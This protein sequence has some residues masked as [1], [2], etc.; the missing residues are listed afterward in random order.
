MKVLRMC[1]ASVLFASLAWGEAIVRS[2]DE[3]RKACKEHR[4]GV[5]FEIDA[6]VV[7]PAA[8]PQTD[9]T[10]L[11]EGKLTSVVDM[12]TN[13]ADG[14]SRDIRVGDRV[15][16]RGRTEPYPPK[17]LTTANCYDLQFVAAGSLPD[18]PPIRVRDFIAEDH[19]GNRL[20]ALQGS[21]QDVFPDDIDIQHVCTI[22]RDD[23]ASV[24]LSC[25]CP[26]SWLPDFK[27][28]LGCRVIV[29]G[30]DAGRQSSTKP[31]YLGRQVYIS[32]TN[33]FR[34][35]SRPASYP[36]N[37]SEFNAQRV[38]AGGATDPRALAKLGPQII[39]GRVLASWERESFLLKTS[40]GKAVG[41]NLAEGPPPR[42]HA[43]V[44]AVGIVETDLC[45]ITLSRALWRP[46]D[47]LSISE[48]EAMETSLK[49]LFSSG[50]LHYAA[51][52]VESHGKTLTVKGTVKSVT[53]DT[54]G[55]RKLL[56]AEG[57]YTIPVVC[58]P[59]ARGNPPPEEGW[60][61]AVT[62]VCVK[63]SDVWRP[64]V[65]I[66]KIRGIFLVPRSN[67]DLVVLRRSPW[68]TPARFAAA[69]AVLLAAFV[70]VFVWNV[71]LRVMIDRRSREVIMA[72]TEKIK[73][74]LRVEERTRLAADLHDN[75]VQNLTAIAYRITAAQ[76]ALSNRE[77]ETRRILQVAA[78]MLKSCRTSLRQ[79]LWDLRN[80]ALNEPDFETAIRR[81]VEPVAGDA[82]LSIRFAGRRD[83][84]DDTTAHAILN[85]LR[86]LV[87]N[88][89]MHGEAD[90]V[91]IAGEFTPEAARFSVRD[92]GTGFDPIHRPGQD[93]GHFGLD[94]IQ[95]RLENL[96][97]K[98]DINSSAGKGTY[99]RVS[100]RTANSKSERT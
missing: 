46:V 84:L 51:I 100:I 16:V 82:K 67:D 65:P 74:E 35:V 85:I 12:R 88:A 38:T 97:G 70:V 62:G 33:A 42:T 37:V 15:I 31:R 48:D 36:F 17:H 96:N 40:D 95:E 76:G 11:A 9:V 53:Q 10:L 19:A 90:A 47:G 29:T 52:N 61:I 54:D 72:Q 39:R 3:L 30:V 78:K 18:L 55:Y 60:R 28:L 32:G 58:G 92:N 49:S 21:V 34:V 1:L 86:E 99:V 2:P 64:T 22:L 14:D 79:C 5:L 13:Q 71:S 27:S 25:R 93:D 75:T 69:S 20:V 87:S 63:D 56:L 45:D 59:D 26:R 94:G 57:D 91:S 4:C 83:L 81:T 6:Q 24:I 7:I 50:R 68:W 23:T 80:D 44:E 43:S 8:V 41:V 66:P 73:S 77:P 89:T 98:I